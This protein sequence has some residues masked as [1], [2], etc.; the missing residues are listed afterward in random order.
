[1]EGNQHLFNCL[2]RFNIPVSLSLL[3]TSAAADWPFRPSDR[4]LAR[5]HFIW[6][7][8]IRL[9]REREQEGQSEGEREGSKWEKEGDQKEE[10]MGERKG[11]EWEAAAG[12]KTVRWL[13]ITAVLPR[14]SLHWT[15][16]TLTLRRRILIESSREGRRG[17]TTEEE[18][19]VGWGGWDGQAGW[20]TEACSPPPRPLSF[21]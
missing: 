2:T 15:S 18:E 8:F 19:G 9:E 5:P 14:V 6:A 4:P 17:G 1:M 20:W 21:H 7:G 10:R 12:D 3:R 16:T 13:A 11:G